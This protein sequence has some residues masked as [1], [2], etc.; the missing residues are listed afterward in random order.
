MNWNTLVELVGHLSWP[1]TVVASLL[2]FR[3]NISG[4]FNRL[5]SFSAS[6][7]GVSVNF[8]DET[9]AAAKGIARGIQPDAQTKSTDISPKGPY[10]ELKRLE[11]SLH[12][13]LADKASQNNLESTNL[14]NLGI[15][16]KLK[17]VGIITIHD[18]KIIES[19]M[20]IE[21]LANDSLTQVQLNDIREIYEAIKL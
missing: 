6:A 10:S 16:G 15:A 12:R 17:E 3:K 20:E 1:V 19:F 2:I 11:H 7:Q 5:G 8:L 21:K 4:T 18:Y 14:N 13:R 9:I